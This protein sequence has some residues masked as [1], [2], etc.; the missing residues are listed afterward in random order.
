MVF[1]TLAKVASVSSSFSSSYSSSRA[2][3]LTRK[4]RLFGCASILCVLPQNYRLRSRPGE[5]EKRKK[6]KKKLASPLSYPF[7]P[8]AAGPK[9]RTCLPARPPYV[10]NH[11][12]CCSNQSSETGN[13]FTHN[14]PMRP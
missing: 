12:R 9:T 6:R 7:L 13:Y 14:C 1:E 8:G 3:S 4:K 11:H 10:V 2:F 5:D